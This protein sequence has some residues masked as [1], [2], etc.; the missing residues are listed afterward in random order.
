MTDNQGTLFLYYEV[1]IGN[2]QA[3]VVDFTGTALIWKIDFDGKIVGSITVPAPNLSIRDFETSYVGEEV[4][5]LFSEFGGDSFLMGR[6]FDGA[7]NFE[8]LEIDNVPDIGAVNIKSDHLGNLCIYGGNQAW[9]SID[10]GLTWDDITPSHSDLYRITSLEVGWDNHI[11]LTTEGTPV[12][13]SRQSLQ[14]PTIINVTVYEDVNG[15]CSY[16]TGDRSVS[17]ISVSFNDSQTRITDSDGNISA[18]SIL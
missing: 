12:L 11:Y 17:G 14:P 5:V 9:M 2:D 16:D 4:H 7:D 18:M 10:K 3:Y 1:A 15:D 6:S 8:Y 13:K